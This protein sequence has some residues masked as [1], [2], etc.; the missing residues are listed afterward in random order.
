M[1]HD[2]RHLGSWCRST[3]QS[4]LYHALRAEVTRLA[5][6][7]QEA[8]S[9]SLYAFTCRRKMHSAAAIWSHHPL[10][11]PQPCSS[12]R[13]ASGQVDDII[14]GL[15]SHSSPAKEAQKERIAVGFTISHPQ[16]LGLPPANTRHW[17]TDTGSKKHNTAQS[18]KLFSSTIM[19]QTTTLLA[20]RFTTV[21]FA[22]A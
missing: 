9:V 14:R 21:T 13:H 19:A 5:L 20:T 12:T 17:S 6:L 10:P 16:T 7:M 15:S 2:Q 1:H 22:P 4:G 3:S 18:T 11:L 8:P